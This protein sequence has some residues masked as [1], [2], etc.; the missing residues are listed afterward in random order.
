[1]KQ[2]KSSDLFFSLNTIEKVPKNGRT[3]LGRGGCGKVDLIS[4]ISD[5]DKLFAM[6][7][8]CLRNGISLHEVQNEIELH[9]SLQHPSIIKI[10]GSQIHEGIAYLFLEYAK[11]GDLFHL[12]QNENKDI[13][14][15]SKKRKFKIFYQCVSVLAYM[16]DKGIVHRDVKPENVLLDENFD[17]RLCDFEWAIKLSENSRR[18]T[19]CGTIEYMAPETLNGQI[20]TE[21]TDIWALGKIFM[22]CH[23]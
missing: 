2:Q 22:L 9:K 21:K 8:I 12:I 15:L 13:Q 7:S 18:K 16:H 23:F 6:K 19:L 20:Q 10:Y 11:F 4:H 14:K 17:V 1:M 3:T 5:P